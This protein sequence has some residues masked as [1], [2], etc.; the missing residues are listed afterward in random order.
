MNF[1]FFGYIG[2]IILSIQLIP[3]VLKILKT[4]STKDLS[5]TFLLINLLGLL[6]TYVYGIVENI[7]PLF[8]PLSF[9][10]PV[11]ILIIA[12]KL[13]HDR[14]STSTTIEHFD[15]IEHL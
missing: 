8:Y 1:D 6:C 4:Q 10:I 12:L 3:Q 14:K 5:L 11:T 2:G 15:N 9:S 13:Y 7:K